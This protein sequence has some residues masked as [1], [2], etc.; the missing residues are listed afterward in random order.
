MDPH[1]QRLS[2]RGTARASK[3][4]VIKRSDIL[5]RLGSIRVPTLV[6]CG[7]E[8]RATVPVHSERIAQAIAGAKLVYIEGAGHMSALEQPK[9]VNDALVPFVASQVGS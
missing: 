4:V 8:D 2:A 1:P 9:A 7:R 3:A 5:A 6:L